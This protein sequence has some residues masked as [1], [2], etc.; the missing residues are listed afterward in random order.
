M[1]RHRSTTRT[2]HQRSQNAL[3]STPRQSEGL[4]RPPRQVPEF[5]IA[6]PCTV[7]R[8]PAI[9]RPAGD[10]RVNGVCREMVQKTPRIIF[11][12][13]FERRNRTTVAAS[14]PSGPGTGKMQLTPVSLECVF[15]FLTKKITAM[16]GFRLRRRS[17][18]W[19]KKRYDLRNLFRLNHNI[20]PVA[21]AKSH[22]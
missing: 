16:N 10:R 8:D 13:I 14:M 9:D 2:P 7:T 1:R 5:S 19:I 15:N 11:V 3:S 22:A 18:R 6:R 20:A 21:R 12:A 4:L 17:Q